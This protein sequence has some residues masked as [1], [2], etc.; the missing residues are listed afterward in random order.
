MKETIKILE[1][2]LGLARI[3]RRNG[4]PDEAQA[5]LELE[6]E[7]TARIEGLKRDLAR[8]ETPELALAGDKA[9]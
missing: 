6:V 9:A 7:L 5:A 8:V 4:E 1:Q 3:K 2:F